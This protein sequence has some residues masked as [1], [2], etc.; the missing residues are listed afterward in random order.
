MHKLLTRFNNNI[1]CLNDLL[2]RTHKLFIFF[3]DN[4]ITRL[5]DLICRSNKFFFISFKDDMDRWLQLND[6]VN[7]SY[8][9]RKCYLKLVL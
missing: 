6:P 7:F 3:F 8:F 2:C 4:I 9:Y 5:N 1:T